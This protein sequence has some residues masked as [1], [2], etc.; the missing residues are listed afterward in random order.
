MNEVSGVRELRRLDYR[1]SKMA[2]SWNWKHKREVRDALA[3]TQAGPPAQCPD[4]PVTPLGSPRMYLA[5]VMR[6]QLDF[7]LAHYVNTERSGWEC[8]G[9]NECKRLQRVSVWLLERFQ[10][11]VKSASTAS[12]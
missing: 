12:D 10:D 1:G 2:L 4:D 3:E 5:E 11:E 9:C 8:A 7:L 6:E